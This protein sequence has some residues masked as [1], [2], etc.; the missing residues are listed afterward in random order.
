MNKKELDKKKESVRKKLEIG[1]GKRAT[2]VEDELKHSS[3]CKQT[4]IVVGDYN[5][6]HYS[7]T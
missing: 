5:D 7:N 4:V 2:K 1:S 6:I 3:K